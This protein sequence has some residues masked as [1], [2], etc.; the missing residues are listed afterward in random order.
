MQV[1][2]LFIMI[3]MV[4]VYIENNNISLS[5]SLKSLSLLMVLG[6]LWAWWFGMTHS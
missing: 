6:S 4:I 3:F 5:H 1:N 2:R